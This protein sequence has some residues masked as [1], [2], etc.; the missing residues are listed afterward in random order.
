MVVSKAGPLSDAT[1]EQPHLAELCD[2]AMLNTST[3]RLDNQ[4]QFYSS[5]LVNSV[6]D[7]R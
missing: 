6:V 2:W 5:Y 4:H 1:L 7:R 3:W